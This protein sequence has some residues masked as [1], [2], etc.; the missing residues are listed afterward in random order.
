MPVST[1]GKKFCPSARSAK[2]GNGF[3]SQS[4][5]PWSLADYELAHDLIR[6]PVPTFRDHALERFHALDA[7]HRL[8]R[9]GDLRR[10]IEAAGQ[11][12]LDLGVLGQHQHHADLAVPLGIETLD[13][14]VERRAIA[15]EDAQ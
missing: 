8:D 6:K 7:R 14:I 10:D 13:D 3:A 2:V 4:S 15:Q 1:S 12:D 9:A 11:L 5:S